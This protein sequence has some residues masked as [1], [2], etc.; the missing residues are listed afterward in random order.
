[1]FGDEKVW[2]FATRSQAVIT[3]V[4]DEQRKTKS[5]LSAHLLPQFIVP[6]RLYCLSSPRHQLA[7]AGSGLAPVSG[8]S[9]LQ[10]LGRCTAPSGAA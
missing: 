5:E 4:A 7:A 8:Q 3:P 9:E 6:T 10:L 1:M 2:E